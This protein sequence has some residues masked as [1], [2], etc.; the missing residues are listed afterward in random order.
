M[1]YL[2]FVLRWMTTIAATPVTEVVRQQ[3]PVAAATVVVVFRRLG[4]RTRPAS[5]IHSTPAF[6]EIGKLSGDCAGQSRG[7]RRLRSP[8]RGSN[9]HPRF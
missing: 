8:E 6:D 3:R 1:P 9:F 5:R 4:W 2:L 7:A